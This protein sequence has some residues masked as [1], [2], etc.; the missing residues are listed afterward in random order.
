MNGMS[1]EVVGGES[2]FEP[3]TPIEVDVA[4]DLERMPDAV[5]LRVV[6]NTSGKGDT[7]VGVAGTERFVSPPPRDSRR[8]AVTLPVAPYSFSGKL[9]SL[10][11]ALELVA[12]PQEES[13][14]VEITIAP[15]GQEVN[16]LSSG[17]S[18]SLEESESG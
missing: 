17:D 15:G 2:G 1:I 8:V 4:W 5:E 7:D 3:G 6:W 11:W 9:I 12:L 14:R 16:I 13:T 10:I 18:W